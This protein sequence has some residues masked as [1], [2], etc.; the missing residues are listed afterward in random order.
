SVTVNGRPASIAAWTD[1]AI[2]IHVPNL[3]PGPA[4]VVVHVGAIAADPLAFTVLSPP[5]QPP[6]VNLLL[7]PLADGR[8][9]IDTSL[10]VDPDGAVSGRP[11]A[12]LVEND[13]FNGVRQ[14]L[15]SID[16]GRFSASQTQARQ[17]APGRH[18]ITVRALE[19]R[20]AP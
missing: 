4:R 18:S 17:L 2:R 5:A 10:T 13:L 3:A 19:P 15:T 20:H 14:L 8:L 6:L 1:T 9:L 16:G 12:G 11:R 7:L